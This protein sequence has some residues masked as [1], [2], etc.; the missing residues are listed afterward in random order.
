[1]HLTTMYCQ[2]H[3]L[4]TSV[5]EA[6]N[7][8][9]WGSQ[10][11]G[12]NPSNPF[13]TQPAQASPFATNT[14]VS[15][16][17]QASPFGTPSTSSPFMTNTGLGQK[18]QNSPLASP[19][20]TNT[21]APSN[22]SLANPFAVT[23]NRASVILPQQAPVDPWAVT[24]QEIAK[25]ELLFSQSG[26]SL[27]GHIET[28]TAITL[29]QQTGLTQEQLAKV[30]A[31]ADIDKDNKFS[32]LEFS[33]ALHLIEGKRLKG[34]EIP[35]VLPPSIIQGL[36]GLQAK[37]AVFNPFATNVTQP[38]VPTG[39]TP[40]ELAGR[41]E[42]KNQ[43]LAKLQT[44]AELIAAI[45]AKQKSNQALAQK[46][47][48]MNHGVEFLNNSNNDLNSVLTI[49]KN[50]LVDTQG[51]VNGARS[52][53]QQLQQTK[54]EREK[55][56]ADAQVKFNEEESKLAT[57]KAQAADDTQ[58]IQKLTD[59]VKVQLELLQK[60]VD[61][62][63]ASAKKAE[64][65]KKLE[66]ERK[67]KEEKER[68]RKELQSQKD[69]QKERERQEKA[70]KEKA[71]KEKADAA[72]ASKAKAT[73]ATGLN[74]NERA[75]QQ[76]ASS[77]AYYEAYVDDFG[78]TAP[79]AP[80]DSD[81]YFGLNHATYPSAFPVFPDYS[82]LFSLN[83]LQPGQS[84][85]QPQPQPVQALP[86][87]PTLPSQPVQ[88]VAS[89][90][91]QTLPQIGPVTLT[92]HDSSDTDSDSDDSDFDIEAHRAALEEQKRKL[93]KEREEIQNQ[94]NSLKLGS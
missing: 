39:P 88:P 65:D 72:K 69:S 43:I 50:H 63:N 1:M 15:P 18:P 90:P 17:A 41:E 2:G 79:H 78:H 27:S 26:P 40:Q 4:P 76:P 68:L 92:A 53:V 5:P 66:K 81:L 73:S 82:Q 30:W 42:A 33:V 94:M 91:V 34:M 22:P 38:I 57:Y 85:P 16:F 64:D 89:V 31:L 46:I 9:A 54:K 47:V 74:T 49:R 71:D 12:P 21:N 87:L 48:E 35:D 93:A 60:L 19:F 28:Q 77:L 24:P 52:V 29:F 14:Q 86:V 32:K 84:Q 6:L 55:A 37:P 8:K 62:A 7:I 44:K 58:Q 67:A 25:Y 51:K 59:D 56:I 11:Q 70:D 20:M 45:Q 61:N 83:V 10:P 3:Q 36:Q 80:N 23:S 75:A 13:G